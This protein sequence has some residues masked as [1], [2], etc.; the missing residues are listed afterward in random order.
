MSSNSFL[1][2]YSKPSYWE[3]ANKSEGIQN[4]L[5]LSNMNFGLGE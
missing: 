2:E 3:F 4:I 1:D 5:T